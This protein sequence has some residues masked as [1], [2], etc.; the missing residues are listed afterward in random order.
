M[1]V[2]QALL[3]PAGTLQPVEF[4]DS[5]LEKISPF[6]R[7]EEEESGSQQESQSIEM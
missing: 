3:Q 2:K 5:L 1:A 6:E 7:P 4:V